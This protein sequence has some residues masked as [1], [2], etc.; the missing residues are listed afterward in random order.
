MQIDT[1]IADDRVT[2]ANVEQLI[3]QTLQE[4]T[5]GLTDD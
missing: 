2:V 5:D 3:L 1:N 4:H